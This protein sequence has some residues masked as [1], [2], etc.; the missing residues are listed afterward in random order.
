MKPKTQI[1]I[2]LLALFIAF[3]VSVVIV[4]KKC[5]KEAKRSST[6]GTVAAINVALTAHVIDSNLT[7]VW[8]SATEQWQFLTDQQYDEAICKLDDREYNLDAS[9]SRPL[10]D[11]WGNRLVIGY[12]KSSDRFYDFVVVSK[13]PD[14][15][16]GTVD[17]VVS[18]YG[19]QSPPLTSE[20][21]V[22]NKKQ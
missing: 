4:F 1:Q 3:I 5:A 9:A 17:D 6:S 13:G 15:I 20:K 8:V 21:Q 16:Y 18:P 19:V 11:F 12:R 14:R 7:Q 22:K 2:G 10:L